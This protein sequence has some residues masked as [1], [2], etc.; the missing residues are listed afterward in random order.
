VISTI[1]AALGLNLNYL[2]NE[3]LRSIVDKQL[4]FNAMF[5]RVSTDYAL[6]L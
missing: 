3:K 4:L 1:E 5:D 6:L 2:I